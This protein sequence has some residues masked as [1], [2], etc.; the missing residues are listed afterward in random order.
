[1]RITHEADYAIRVMYCLAAAGERLSA[2]DIAEQTGVTLRFSL[3]ILRKLIQDDLI[4]SFKGVSGGYIL[5]H[6]ANEISL[7]QIIECID[8]P[9]MINHCLSN[10]F[11]CSRVTRKSECDF[12]K[13]FGSIN[14]HLRK[15]L[16]SV[17]LDQFT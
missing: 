15:E 8:G 2:K 17:T 5:N 10:E 13:V 12:H 16:Y 9:I 4:K 6:P 11:D 3:K 7:G 1:M 14:A